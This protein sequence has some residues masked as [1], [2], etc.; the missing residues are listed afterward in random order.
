MAHSAPYFGA[1][2]QCGEWGLA[3]IMGVTTQQKSSNI[4]QCCL[5]TTL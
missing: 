2:N 4:T 5:S 3:T 1:Q